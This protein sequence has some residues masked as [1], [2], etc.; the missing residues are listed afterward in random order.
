[1]Q[2]EC[3]RT[4]RYGVIFHQ[5]KYSCLGRVT[6]SLAPPGGGLAQSHLVVCLADCPL[7]LRH[8]IAT[9][10]VHTIIPFPLR[11]SLNPLSRFEHSL[12]IVSNGAINQC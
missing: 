9:G 8:G 4:M 6:I 2:I 7:R 1:M 11:N 5:Q 3:F 12:S 10:Q